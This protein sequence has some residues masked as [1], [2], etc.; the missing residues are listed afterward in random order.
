[1][2]SLLINDEAYLHAQIINN[3]FINDFKPGKIEL[4]L[5]EKS[6]ENLISRLSKTL[7]NIT[8]IKWEIVEI[9]SNKKETMAE[10]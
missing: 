4:E 9:I 6:D 2:L 1:M 8:K 10:E 5:N 7:E 3:I